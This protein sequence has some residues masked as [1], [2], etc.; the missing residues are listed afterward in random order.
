MMRWDLSRAG[1][2]GA[3]LILAGLLAACAGSP[4]D[5]LGLS[6]DNEPVQPQNAA[7]DV[8]GNGSV[9]VALILPISSQNGQAAAQSL[10]NAAEL[11]VEDFSGGNAASSNIQIIVKDDRG[12]PEGARLAAQEAVQEGAELVLGP[13]FAPNVQAAAAVLRPAGKPMIAFSS[14]A[15]VA[16]RGVFLLSFLPQSDVQRVVGFAQ[17]R[18]KKAF[19]ALIPQTAYGNVIEAEFMSVAN[20]Q[21]SR[22]TRVERYQPGNTASISQAAQRLKDVMNQSDTLFVGE[23]ADGLAAVMQQLAAQGINSRSTQLISTGI[24]NDPRAIA[25]PALEGAWFAAPD[26]S[27]FNALAT[28]Y[29]QRFGSTPTRL[30]TLS[31]DAVTL[32]SALTQAYGAQRFAENNL[33]NPNGFAGQ[34]GVFRFR[35]NG[36]NDRGIAVFEIRGGNARAISSAPTSFAGN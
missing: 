31:Y 23:G 3:G 33:T 17:S 14:D 26:N 21:G 12:T 19:A 18:G 15:G 5:S 9:K 16:Q 36:L 7:G 13:L 24:W 25:L 22:V 30:A 34:D 4:L 1:R 11:A 10:R 32:A 29:Q 27:R 35:T 8:I 20:Q 28:R 6:S 2:L